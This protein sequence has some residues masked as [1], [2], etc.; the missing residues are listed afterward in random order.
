MSGGGG[1]GRTGDTPARARGRS[2]LVAS[3]RRR[4]LALVDYVVGSMILAGAL[5]AWVGLT[6]AKAQAIGEVHAQ[7]LALAAAEEALDGVRRAGLPGMPEG[8]ADAAGFRLVAPFAPRAPGLPGAAGRLEA[9]A[10]Q[11]TEGR[12]HGLFEVRAVV[13]WG[14]PSA[15]GR[16]RASLS[17]VLPGPGGGS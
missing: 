12:A 10:L 11:T 9:R 3:R 1:L 16:S 7:A 13:R 2:E 4:G 6:R 15:D 5:T 8:P 14:P 17:T